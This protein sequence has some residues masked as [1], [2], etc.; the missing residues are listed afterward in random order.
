MIKKF[1]FNGF[2]VCKNPDRTET[3]SG[4]PHIEI[5][6]AYVRGKWTYGVTYMPAGRLE[7]TSATRIGSRHRK[8][9]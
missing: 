9:P 7:L 2:G 8:M 3:G 5:S 4:I 1:L 6:T